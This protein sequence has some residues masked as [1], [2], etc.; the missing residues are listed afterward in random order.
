MSLGIMGISNK[1]IYIFCPANIAT[2][3]TEALHQLRYYM[4]KI[5]LDAYLVYINVMKGINPMPDR[6]IIYDPK[7][8]S[9]EEIEDVES[10]IVI[11]P[12]SWSILLNNFNKSKKCIWWLS[13][14]FYDNLPQKRIRKL[15]NFVKI[16]LRMKEKEIDRFKFTIHNCI[17][18]CGS[19]YAYDF[20]KKQR[21]KGIKYLVEP[22]SKEF[23][24]Y[25]NTDNIERNNII[26]YN[27]AKPSD[28][29]DRL[30]ECNEFEFMPLKG[31]NPF[32]LIDIYRNAKLYIDFGNFGG[33]ERI[34]KEAVFFGCTILVGNRNA[35]KNNFDVAI[36]NKYKIKK[37][38]DIDLVKNKIKFMLDNYET[39]I[40]DFEFFSNKIK[41]LETNFIK[42][43]VN[44]FYK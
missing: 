1:I 35:A 5:K 3:G 36:L 33:P 40:N 30:L 6:Y 26:L 17:N 39:N 34:P 25:K 41:N 16:L 2:G 31:F 12:E 38:Y 37:Y 20:L 22:I 15:K 44:I 42:Q 21:V 4:E 13:V 27:P 32:Q 18:L 8:K 24:E 14:D 10:N 43:I 23:L 7:V 29:M 19:K 11:A 28:I 9:L